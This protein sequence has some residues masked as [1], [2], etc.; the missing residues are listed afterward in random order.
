M[1]IKIRE[2]EP[3]ELPGVI[4]RLDQEFI[5]NKQH[6]LSLGK[7]FPNTLSLE[8]IK[9]IRVAVSDGIILGSISIRM[10][11]WVA[12]KHTWHGAMVG[13]VYID[14]QYRGKGIGSDLLSSAMEL[15][16]EKDT[17]FGVLWTGSPVFYE[18]AGW[19]LN[20][21]GLFGKAI[22]RFNSP[23]SNTVSCRP[24]V[25]ADSARLNRIRSALLP[26]RVMRSSLD[27]STVPIP[28]VQLFC[29][30][31]QNDEGEGY[32]LVGEQDGIGYFYEMT[33]PSSLWSMIWYAVT[34]R[35][36]QLF[37]NGSSGDPFAQWLS[38]EKLVL[39][40]PHN[41]AMWFDVSGRIEGFS[42]KAWH[43]PYFDWI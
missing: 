35:F 3:R 28:A 33:A 9:Q 17:D 5:F 18:R 12:Q 13:M 21:R 19:I 24:L 15:L 1:N 10:F 25:S 4:D 26:I 22:N 20:D 37:V 39:W 36:G 41:K 6:S 30:S 7:R 38:D 23:R 29:F 27:Y 31:A 32:A 40:Q 14:P 8:N 34:E 11:R 16:H 43:I 2:C 42:I